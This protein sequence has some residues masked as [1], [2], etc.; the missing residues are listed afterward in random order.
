MKII[1]FT[2]VCLVGV[3]SQAL[4]LIK[5]V[6]F[7]TGAAT[8]GMPI[9]HS[10]NKGDFDGVLGSLQVTREPFGYAGLVP[11]NTAAGEI[12]I[13][14][15][16]TFMA[17]GWFRA[18]AI[19]QN[20]S[21]MESPDIANW[22]GSA[23]GLQTASH[24][25]R[26][27][28]GFGSTG[29]VW[30]NMGAEQV[31][32]TNSAKADWVFVAITASAPVGSAI[33]AFRFY[34]GT[35]MVLMRSNLGVQNYS[36]LGT[37]QFGADTTGGANPWKGKIAFPAVYSIKPDY[38]DVAFPPDMPVINTK[39][40]TYYLDTVSGSDTND[41]ATPLTAWKTADRFVYAQT[42]CWIAP[43]SWQ[44]PGWLYAANGASAEALGDTNFCA[45]VKSGAVIN[46]GDSIL[47]N[48]DAAPLWMSRNLW[49]PAW[50]SHGIKV[51]SFGTNRARM[52]FGLSLTNQTW[53]QYDAGNYPNI[54]QTTNGEG[55][56][57][58]WEDWKWMNSPT[59][60][61]IVA[62]RTNLNANHGSF[63]MDGTTVYLHA[64]GS[65]NPN[66]NGREYV[67]SRT[68][69]AGISGG[70]TW[71]SGV[72]FNDATNGFLDALD[73]RGIGN[74]SST[75][76]EIVAVYA[77]QLAG[78]GRAVIRNSEFHHGANHAHGSVHDV[79]TNFLTFVQGSFF[80]D[81]PPL[82]WNPGYSAMVEHC[83]N[84]GTDRRA[85][86]WD[87]DFSQMGVIGGGYTNTGGFFS[88]DGVT[89]TNLYT[90]L[91]MSN[92]VGSVVVGSPTEYMIRDGGWLIEDS[93]MRFLTPGGSAPTV[94]RC[95]IDDAVTAAY[96]GMDM[97][98]SLV[99]MIYTSI[100]G[101]GGLVTF[102]N[103]PGYFYAFNRC[104]F[105][106]SMARN[107]GPNQNQALF[108]LSA[109]GDARMTN[110]VV[111]LPPTNHCLVV[112]VTDGS[113]KFS[114][115]NNVYFGTNTMA[116]ATNDC[117]YEDPKLTA[118]GRPVFGSP[119]IGRGLGGIRR[120][121]TGAWFSDRVTAGAYEYDAT[122]A[123]SNSDGIPDSWN[124][125]YGLDPNEIDLMHHDP[126]HD[127]YSTY[128]EWIAD[129][130]PV[131]SRSFFSIRSIAGNSRLEVRFTGSPE[132]IYTLLSATHSVGGEHDAFAWTAVQ[133]QVGIR[134]TGE[135]S[136]LTDT[137][138]QP[139]KLYRILVGIPQ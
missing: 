26:S 60:A 50:W 130:S 121:I 35:N 3:H 6:D 55:M 28:V 96:K 59:G 41:G 51:G 135:Q 134:G 116:G 9:L 72:H 64:F 54:W 25:T 100:D 105:D 42:N 126:D 56:S 17:C 77:V 106:F 79:L 71:T 70:A 80:G 32:L 18:S 29:G 124:L 8:N 24:G 138:T 61:T 78:V 125:Q 68:L 137:N 69:L 89:G 4:T 11:H 12:T 20:D 82:E 109:N 65:G 73:A 95:R 37:A 45:L 43:R 119:A 104:T 127:G 128:Q 52:Y 75:N 132:R 97:S 38:S 91:W 118:D 5:R 115:A 74:R 129:T 58:V 33:Y 133:G 36:K 62:V 31:N 92:C 85:I 81:G 117:I 22:W 66:G 46:S 7:S 88:H 102:T 123:D 110:C 15:T 112:G 120:D 47:L 98:D 122:K 53:T 93:W 113:S 19:A 49:L 57:I 34:A 87:L 139:F 1:V 94:R 108:Y 76:G 99:R 13:G 21:G 83:A 101:R 48:T 131:D 90:L 16:N 114:A 40:M 10:G 23:L 44:S 111:I 67:R 103:G 39:P 14:T 27:V 84:T 30:W 63:Y 107:A 86:Y 2:L 136:V